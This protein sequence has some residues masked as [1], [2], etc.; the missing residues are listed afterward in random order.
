MKHYVCR[1]LRLLSFLQGEGFKFVGVRKDK[2]NRNYNVW[3]FEDTSE[4]R[5]A[6]ERYYNSDEFMQRNKAV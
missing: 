5:E 4:L 6:I 1:K 2:H 3:L